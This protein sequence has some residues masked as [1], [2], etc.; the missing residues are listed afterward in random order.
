[1]ARR[2][3]GVS[4]WY[5]GPASPPSQWP[6]SANIARCVLGRRQT[7]ACRQ[8]ARRTSRSLIAIRDIAAGELFNTGNVRSLRPNIGLPPLYQDRIMGLA[9]SRDIR[10]GEGVTADCLDPADQDELDLNS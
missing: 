9:A 8:R 2:S 1:M 5:Q 4:P 10:R 6:D 7:G 3:C